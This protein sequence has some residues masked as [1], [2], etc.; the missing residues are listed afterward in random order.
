MSAAAA[1]AAGASE[2]LS[3]GTREALALLAGGAAVGA[4]GALVLDAPA[5]LGVPVWTAA[6]LGTAVMLARLTGVELRGEGRWMAVPALLFAGALAWRAAPALQVLN[7]LAVALCLALFAARSRA[8]SLRVE[9]LGGY[10]RSLVNSGL[11]VAGGAPL[12]VFEDARLSELRERRRGAGLAAALRGL[13]LA[14]PLL[15]LFGTLFR[16]ADPVFDRVVGG[17]VR[18]DAAELLADVW[19]AVV[20]G[21]FA[22]GL[23]R[24]GLRRSDPLATL[25]RVPAEGRLLPR[26][27]R[28]LGRVEAGVVLGS[29]DL[30]FLAFVAVQFRYLFG[31]ETL[32]ETTVGMTYAEYARRGFFELVAVSAL[33]MPLLLALDAVVD[34]GPPR[35]RRLHRVLSWTLVALLMLVIAS[36]LQRMRLYQE[37]YGLTEQRLYATAFIVWLAVVC[38]WLG[39][40]VLRGRRERFAWGALV[41][42]LLVLAALNG[43]SPDAWIARVNLAH[44]ER[45]GRLDA[46]YLAGLGPD[47]APVVLPR[48]AA[49]DREAAC[50]LASG[51]MARA[52]S[53]GEWTTWNWGRARAARGLEG[54]DLPDVSECRRVD[55]T[56]PPPRAPA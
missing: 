27:G 18:G 30:L 42:G 17:L 11:S 34:D 21:W 54:V 2:G 56:R 48:L 37:A 10:L 14:L 1:G 52:R 7:T 43:M 53:T 4:L 50:A 46:G 20:W 19:R 36:A 24:L 16:S 39:A 3:R 26:T 28:W 32:V 8:G 41:S 13:L 6:L 47:A 49:L 29:L 35:A 51:P 9:G 25:L 55:R 23:L 31:G 22:A 40:T 33:T 45:T 38:A 12:L 44:G 5:G 15:L